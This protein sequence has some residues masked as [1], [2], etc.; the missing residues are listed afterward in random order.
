MKNQIR[1]QK[2]DTTQLKILRQY[3]DPMRD[4]IGVKVGVTNSIETFEVYNNRS[5][6]RLLP[7]TSNLLRI[8]TNFRMI[9][10]FFSI[11]PSFFPGN[12]DDEIKG[13]TDIGG[14]GLGFTFFNWFADL[15]YTRT[16]GYYLDNTE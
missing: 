15:G 14:F 8:Y 7:N 16:K 5:N 3:I 9:S 4:V 12:D 1:A 10:F 6:L 2:I 11:N 13:D